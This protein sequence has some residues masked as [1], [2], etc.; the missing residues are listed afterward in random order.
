MPVLLP[1]SRGSYRVRLSAFDVFWAAASPLLA[2]YLRDAYILNP[3]T[4]KETAPLR[5]NTINGPRTKGEFWRFAKAEG[6]AL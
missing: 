5:S 4:P 6:T 1:S 3:G 2:L